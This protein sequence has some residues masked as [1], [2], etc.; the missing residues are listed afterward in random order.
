MTAEERAAAINAQTAMFRCEME[1]MLAE[2]QHRLHVGQTVAYGEDAFLA[3][4]ARWDS[5]LGQN[6]LIRFFNP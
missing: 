5:V 3:L 6:A 1:G 4:Q 2:N